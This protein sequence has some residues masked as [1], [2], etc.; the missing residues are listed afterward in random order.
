MNDKIKTQFI[1]QKADPNIKTQ[2]CRDNSVI[3]S[4][5]NLIFEAYNWNVECPELIRKEQ[6]NDEVENDYTAVL[7]LFNKTECEEDKLSTNEIFDLCKSKQIPFTK[8]KISK[9]LNKAG[10]PRYRT[11]DSRGF[12][13]IKM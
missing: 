11:A 12:T 13:N 8:D 5:I 2:F 3:N 9:I 7:E 6:L 1:R 4:F 10:F